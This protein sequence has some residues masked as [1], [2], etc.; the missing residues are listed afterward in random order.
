MIHTGI[1]PSQHMLPSSSS[2][3]FALTPTLPTPT[4]SASMHSPALPESNP[5]SASI[6]P[7]ASANPP[8][9]TSTAAGGSAPPPAATAP[10]PKKKKKQKQKPDLSDFIQADLQR[11]RNRKPGAVQDATAEPLKTS[12][13]PSVAASVSM[14]ISP[15]DSPSMSTVA[16]KKESELE[17]KLDAVP[18]KPRESVDMDISPPQSPSA[19]VHSVEDDVVMDGDVGVQIPPADELTPALN[20]EVDRV[21]RTLAHPA[22]LLVGAP[23]EPPDV[24]IP[25]VA[26]REEA[27]HPE[28]SAPVEIPVEPAPTPIVAPSLDSAA[29][30]SI[31]QTMVTNANQL[32]ASSSGVNSPAPPSEIH[33]EPEDATSS[34][35]TGIEQATVIARHRG[36]A[37]GTITVDFLINQNQLDSITKWNRRGKDPENLEES[38][39][40]TLLCLLSAD[41]KARVEMTES[42]NFSTL[43]PEL[44]CSWPETGGLSMG[45]L[46]DGELVDMPLA[47][48][49]ALPSNGLVDVSPFLGLGK[50]TIT[51]N[52][53]RDMTKYLIL[54]CAHHPTRSQLDSISRGKRRWTGWLDKFSQPLQLPFR[55]PVQT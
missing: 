46:W 7:S 39:C 22:H 29:L 5:P 33:V 37:S 19:V 11:H 32:I 15:M 2:L 16:I 20:L 35:K 4:S 18:H 44:E 3:A 34:R 45:A 21:L 53:T 12:R 8:M 50:N 9:S 38:L 26:D 51:I 54:L 36:L 31:L 48:P 28:P 14:D 47:P 41:V 17:Q 10:K 55:I 27:I 6:T 49:F 40:V 30:Q 25:D 43:L 13:D 52:Q 24:V 1:S 42:R 23:D